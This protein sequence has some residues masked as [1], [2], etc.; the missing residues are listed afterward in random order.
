MTGKKY[1]LNLLQSKIRNVVIVQPK[2]EHQKV[3]ENFINYVK[4]LYK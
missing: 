4:D 3:S 2:I 1:K